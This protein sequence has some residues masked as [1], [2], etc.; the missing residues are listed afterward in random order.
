MKM[1]PNTKHQLDL[2]NAISYTILNC[3][4]LS[5]TVL[6]VLEVLHD[7]MAVNCSRETGQLWSISDGGG[8]GLKGAGQTGLPGT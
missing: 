2:I 6:A 5:W 4:G 3:P 1:E 8:R 7:W